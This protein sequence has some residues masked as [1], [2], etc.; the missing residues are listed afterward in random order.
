MKKNALT[1]SPGFS[2]ESLNTLYTFIVKGKSHSP[3]EIS[4]IFAAVAEDKLM[5]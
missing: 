2:T 1:F 5:I 4:S 3:S